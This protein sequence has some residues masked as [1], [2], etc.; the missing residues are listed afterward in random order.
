MQLTLTDVITEEQMKN[1]R[2]L[3]DIAFPKEERKPFSLI[4]QKRDEGVT[5][6]LAIEDET[7]TFYG[8]VIT[9]LYKDIVLLDYFAIAEA[10]RGGGVGSEIL[11]L[12]QERC[13]GRRLLLEIEDTTRLPGIEETEVRVNCVRSDVSEQQLSPEDRQ[14]IRRKAFY[15]R[16]RM[17]PMNYRVELFGVDMEILTYPAPVAYEEYH[18]IF[19]T[20]YPGAKFVKRIS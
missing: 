4:L 18:E 9:I 12:L 20:V 2:E 8:L 15:L 10:R 1:V 11:R 6:I 14:K 5:E 7:G 16:N 17:R 19:E 13:E 3:Y